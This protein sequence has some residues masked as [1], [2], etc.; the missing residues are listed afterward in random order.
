MVYS[1]Q[2]DACM[3]ML[4]V[5]KVTGVYFKEFKSLKMDKHTSHNSIL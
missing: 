3:G 4:V 1:D 5:T 2:G